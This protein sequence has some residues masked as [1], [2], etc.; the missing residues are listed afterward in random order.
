MTALEWDKV[1]ERF[2]ETGVDRGVLYPRDGVAV[3]WNGL[4]NITEDP[5]REVKSYYLDGIKYLDHYVP[6]SYS[7]KLDAFTYPDELEELTGTMVYAPGVFLHDQRAKV[8]HL[9][10]RTGVGNDIDP[11]L[12]YKIHILYNV[13]AVP[14]GAGLAS[15]NDRVAPAAFSWALTGTPPQMFGVRPTSHVSLHS[16]LID[17]GLLETIEGLLYGTEDADPAL[18]GMVDLL[19]LIEGT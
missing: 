3:P 11:N 15:L 17:P 10:Y 19:T 2:F 1:G 18:P 14:A 13:M 6:G 8:F 9:S 5:S 16:R 7:A 12:G 4:T